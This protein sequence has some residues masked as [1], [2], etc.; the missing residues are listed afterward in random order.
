MDSIERF[1]NQLKGKQSSE[2]LRFWD[3][4]YLLQCNPKGKNNINRN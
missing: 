1:I 4:I 2:D 3:K